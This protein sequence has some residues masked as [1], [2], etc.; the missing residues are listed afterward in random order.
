MD[1]NDIINTKWEV[2]IDLLSERTIATRANSL[3][4][5]DYTIIVY[6]L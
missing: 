6:R 4:D 2:S 3:V 5:Y 1:E